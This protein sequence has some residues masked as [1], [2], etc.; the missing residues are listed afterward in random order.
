MAI[1]EDGLEALENLSAHFAERKCRASVRLAQSVGKHWNFA[2]LGMRTTVERFSFSRIGELRKVIEPP[3]EIELASVLKNQH[4]FGAI[5][6]YSHSITHELAVNRNFGGS[7]QSAFNVAWWIISAIRVKTLAEFLVP[8]V[9]DYSWSVIAALDQQQ[10][11]AQLLEDVPQARRVDD[12]VVVHELDLQWSL[13]HI[14]QFGRMLEIPKF[15]LAVEALTT[16]QHLVSLRMMVAS[17]WS[18][19]EALLG[20]QAELRFRIAMSIASLVEPRGQQRID[21]YRRIK[22]MYDV[23]SRAVH[24]AVMSDAELIS[25]VAEVRKLLS[26]IVCQM[27]EAGKVFSEDDIERTLLE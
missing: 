22:K 10:C 21:Q 24:G 8:A 14:A 9:A 6:R 7:D 4:L 26:I 2:L 17:L 25:H 19:M 23:R 16:H 20:I 18:G 27:V 1:N 3:G 13:A 15:R 11:H 12:P 5:G